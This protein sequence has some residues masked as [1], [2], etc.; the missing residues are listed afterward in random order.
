[1]N[2]VQN[3]C[4]RSRIRIVQGSQHLYNINFFT[5]IHL[6]E[7]LFFMSHSHFHVFVLQRDIYETLSTITPAEN[8]LN[9]RPFICREYF[10]IKLLLLF[11]RLGHNF[12]ENYGKLLS[13]QYVDWDFNG[14]NT[15]HL[16]FLQKPFILDVGKPL[17]KKWK[18]SIWDPWDKYPFWNH[19]RMT[20]QM[21][22]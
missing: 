7:I 1:M 9:F 20:H 12:P 8:Y 14:K 2:E 3:G 5:F 11:S 19:K 16:R 13:S 4:T 17:K 18:F 6:C 21:L 15:S 10:V 22:S